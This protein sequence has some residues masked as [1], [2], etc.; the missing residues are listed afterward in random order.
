MDILSALPEFFST[1]GGIA[2]LAVIAVVLIIA[3]LELNYRFFAKYI[4][5]FLFAFLGV[6][7][8]SPVLIPLSVTAKVRSGSVFSQS[9]CVGRKGRV[10]EVRTFSG[11][12]SGAARLALIFDVLACKLSIVGP[13]LMAAGDAALID[14]EYMDRFNVRPGII[15][16]LVRKGYAEITY[17]EMFAIDNRDISR[18][19][20]FSDGL[21]A[22]AALIKLIRGDGKEYLG[23]TAKDYSEVLLERGTITKEEAETA[24]EYAMQY[25]AEAERAAAQR[26]SLS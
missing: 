17:E 25:V 10:I 26:Q 23:E 19:G 12:K 6:I 14:D 24:K 16:P 2:L 8:L 9:L 4:L 5:D 21:T 11:I 20:M 3:V 13:K 15:S 18:R 7:V 1:A 22:F